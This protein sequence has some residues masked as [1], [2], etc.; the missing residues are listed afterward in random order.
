MPLHAVLWDVDDTL[1]DYRGANADGAVRHFAAEG[2]LA[3]YPSRQAALDH[4]WA[5]MEEHYGRFLAGELDLTGQRRARARAFLGRPLTD[6]EADAWFA[7]YTARFEAAW[8]LFPDVVPALD[9]LAGSHRHAVLS[10]SSERYQRRK[11]GRLGIGDRFEAVLCSDDIGHA[12]PAPEAFLAACRA[13][14]LPP[15]TVAYVGDRSD[16]DAAAATAAGLHGIWLDRAGTGAE[17][18]GPR[19]TTLAELPAL[20][21]PAGPDS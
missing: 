5:V 21:A 11:L 19:I 1:F 8:R 17:G 9:A 18:T 15:A 13:L 3:R 12:K 7:G 2:I 10:N 4:W 16:I 14:D 20:L 6:A